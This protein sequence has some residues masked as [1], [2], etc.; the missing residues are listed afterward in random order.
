MN[1]ARKDCVGKWD[2]GDE[3]DEWME[4]E[5]MMYPEASLFSGGADKGG[6]YTGSGCGSTQ[7]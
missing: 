3:E 6:W 5:G 7:V 4:V 1:T 2:E